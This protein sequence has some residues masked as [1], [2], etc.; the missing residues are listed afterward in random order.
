MKEV[1]VVKTVALVGSLRKDSYNLKLVNHL[2]TTYPELGIEVAEIGNLPFFN[3]EIEANPGQEVRDFQALVKDADAVVI[4]TP[5]YN[6]SIPAVLKNALDWVSRSGRE[7]EGKKVLIMGASMGASMGALGTVKAQI[8]LRDILDTLGVAA[9]I[10][11]AAGGNDV[12]VGSVHEKFDEDGTLT[13][14]LTVQFI[15]A[16]VGRFKN[17]IKI[18]VSL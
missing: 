14:E 1:V 16:I 7:M 10:M 5:E 6:A 11:P 8:H 9:Y 13:D 18:D 17:F 4:A 12:F 3:E 2:A 15:D